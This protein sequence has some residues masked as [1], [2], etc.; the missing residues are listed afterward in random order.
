MGGCH[1]RDYRWRC[2]R[3]CSRRVNWRSRRSSG[4]CLNRRNYSGK[5]SRAVRATTARGL[6]L[7]A[8][9]WST[10]SLLQSLYGTHLRSSRSSA[11]RTHARR[12]YRP[13]LPQSVIDSTIR[14][15]ALVPGAHP[16]GLALHLSSLTIPATSDDNFRRVTCASHQIPCVSQCSGC[17]ARGRANHWDF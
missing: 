11:G 2:D 3:S 10:R 7:R 12:R 17:W 1:G 9:G 5:S 14:I 15:N 16:P 4:W 8:L 13:A 6:A